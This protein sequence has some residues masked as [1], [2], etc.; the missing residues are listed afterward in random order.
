LVSTPG[1]WVIV[2][3]WVGVQI[4]VQTELAGAP[5]ITLTN[6]DITVGVGNNLQ[7]R[8]NTMSGALTIEGRGASYLTSTN[9]VALPGV[10]GQAGYASASVTPVAESPGF[11]W[12]FVPGAE[13]GAGYDTKSVTYQAGVPTT[14]NTSVRVHVTGTP[15]VLAFAAPVLAAI[16]VG[17]PDAAAILAA[18]AAAGSGSRPIPLPAH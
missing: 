15:V 10:H 9:K 1:G 16:G 17:A 2:H 8:A 4:T 18:A 13:W 14:V 11:G 12:R 6:E 7:I 5:N 3:Q